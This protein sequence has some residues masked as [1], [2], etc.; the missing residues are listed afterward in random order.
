[1]SKFI[2]EIHS[3][4]DYIYLKG[5]NH[6]KIGITERGDGGLDLS[7]ANKLSQVD[8]AVIITKHLT[9]GNQDLI[10]KLIANKSKIIL[11]VT[12][13]GFGGTVIEP[14]VPTPDRVI[15]GVLYL[16]NQGF[17]VDQIVLRTDPIVPDVLGQLRASQIWDRFISMGITRIRYSYLDVYKHVYR[18]FKSNQVRMINLPNGRKEYSTESILEFEYYI[19]DYKNTLLSRGISVSFESCA[20]QSSYNKK[21]CIS[22]LDLD[23]LGIPYSTDDLLVDHAQRASCLC[24]AGKTELLPPSSPHPCRSGCMYCYWKY[25]SEK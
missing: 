6:M 21:G 4:Y 9:V 11:H 1:M 10:N 2:S 15:D 12:C 7:W 3:D 25:K 13:T 17:P 18:R 20:E 14:G 19:A 22:S 24:L 8:A 5:V 16:I 23:I